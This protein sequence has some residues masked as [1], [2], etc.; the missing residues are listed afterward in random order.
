MK[1]FDR[2]RALAIADGDVGLME[3]LI[4]LSKQQSPQLLS[5]ISK[6]LETGRL[7]DIVRP[8]H[9][10]KGSAANVG[11]LGAPVSTV[12]LASALAGAASTLP[13]LSLATV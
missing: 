3:E 1:T 13:T 8:A 10:L 9:T 4:N 11:T 12:V 5:T 6:A 7:E 2:D